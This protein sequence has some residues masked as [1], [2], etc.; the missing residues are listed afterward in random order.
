MSLIDDPSLVKG[1]EADLK[2]IRHTGRMIFGAHAVEKALKGRRVKAVILAKNAPE[3]MVSR[4]SS[5]AASKKIPTF[6]STKLNRELG[7]LC[8]RPH[9][10]SALAIL[11][12]GA[13]TMK[14][15]LK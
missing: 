5:M 1:L 3:W 8:G 11:D 14:Q 15:R 4:I 9:I 2:V 13:S 10:I 6:K 7:A 12:F